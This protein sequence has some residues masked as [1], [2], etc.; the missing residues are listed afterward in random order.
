MTS[1]FSPLVPVMLPVL[2]C[3]AIGVFWARFKQPYDAE[4][5]RRSVIWIGAPAL[6][7]GTLGQTQISAEL[8]QQSVV[9]CLTMLACATVIS[10]VFLVIFRLPVRDFL[11][12]MVFGN[13]GNMG[14]P[15]CLFAFGDA[16]LTLALGVFLTTS[17]THFSLGVAVLN[18]RQALKY[19][20]AS[21]LVWSGVL[22]A[23]MV[24]GNWQLP[25]AIQNSLHILGGMA[26]PLMLI[27]LG[28]SLNSL[29]SGAFVRSFLMGLARLGIG[30]AAG[31]AA[32]WLLDLDG[33]LRKV[34]LLQAAT[35]SAVFNYLLALQSRRNPN[36]VAGMVVSST[37]LSFIT[38]PLLLI[39]L[40]VSG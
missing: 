1:L 3:A 35:P 22:A 36:A 38:I 40:G 20:F 31:F 32:V 15:L 11:V 39:Y 6:I 30:L 14:L 18:G 10:L 8:L 2:I 37:V 5:V 29:H 9:A 19:T 7:V 13:T 33:L 21:P 25:L 34:I 26:I 16:G 17:T 28:I 4:F 24:L 27:T 23:W 12:P